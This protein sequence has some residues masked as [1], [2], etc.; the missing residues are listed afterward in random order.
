[1]S[2]TYDTDTH[3]KM[4]AAIGVINSASSAANDVL[5]VLHKL[6]IGE[7]ISDTANRTMLVKKAKEKLQRALLEI[8]ELDVAE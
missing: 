8:D 6:V 1:M 7:E 4:Q 2:R 5:E 3:V